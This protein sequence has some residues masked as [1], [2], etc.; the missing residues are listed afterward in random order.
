MTE[1]RGLQST[2]EACGDVCTVEE[3]Q[4]EDAALGTNPAMLAVVPIFWMLIVYF[5]IYFIYKLIELSMFWRHVRR[6]SR[7]ARVAA[8]TLRQLRAAQPEYHPPTRHV[9]CSGE[10]VDTSSSPLLCVAC[11]GHIAPLTP[12]QALNSCAACGVVAH[13]GCLR[14]VGDSCRPSCTPVGMPQHHFWQV[15]GTERHE[16]RLS[17]VNSERDRILGSVG[18]CL[19]CD[20]EV[21]G[22]VFAVE[23]AW[24]CSCCPAL[25]HV[26]CFCAAHPELPTVTAKFESKMKV[27]TG[28]NA[29]ELARAASVGVGVGAPAGSGAV[30][31]GNSLLGTVATEAENLLDSP[32][33]L[34]TPRISDDGLLTPSG[35]GFNFSRGQSP[36]VGTLSMENLHLNNQQHIDSGVNL[37]LGRRGSIKWK[38]EDLQQLD[39]CSLGP[40]Q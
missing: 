36:E 39:T 34:D 3:H 16:Q 25:T 26:R 27:I 21:A 28:K 14:H 18:P 7:I 40:M 8:S 10:D 32:V 37:V 13:D 20:E 1:E 5:V 6:G 38:K 2:P 24:R 29:S 19:Y 15:A 17:G 4:M 35:L 11:C 23:P 9:W 22:G 31:R 33:T 30:G 12:S